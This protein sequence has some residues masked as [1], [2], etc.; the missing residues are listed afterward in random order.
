MGSRISC[1]RRAERL[2][3]AGFSEAEPARISPPIGLD[4]G[5]ASPP[6]TAHSIFAEIVAVTN[7]RR[8]GRL[9]EA[10]GPIH[11]PA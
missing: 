6:E 8:G 10:D 7:G 5:A 4:L 11:A 1:E 3:E 9:A 2:C